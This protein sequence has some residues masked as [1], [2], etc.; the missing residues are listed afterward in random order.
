MRYFPKSP[1]LVVVAILTFV[2]GFV[3]SS[4][5]LWTS[6]SVAVYSDAT[7]AGATTRIDTAV[8]SNPT[9]QE[10]PDQFVLHLTGV[11]QAAE[12]DSQFSAVVRAISSGTTNH[13]GEDSLLMV[14]D[15]VGA[16]EVAG[17]VR[18]LRWVADSLEI[19]TT[20][21]KADAATGVTF[22]IAAQRSR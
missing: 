14:P 1:R 21:P 20:N 19:T 10:K 6:P 16:G 22:E 7:L 4:L 9:R 12:A 8:I 5:A 3:G 11:S 15:V 18:L 17:E 2:G 13:I